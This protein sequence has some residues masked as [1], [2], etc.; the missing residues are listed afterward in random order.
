VREF[1]NRLV[2]WI[3]APVA[4]KIH[5]EIIC[6]TAV[7]QWF[8]VATQPPVHEGEYEVEIFFG[9]DSFGI[10]RNLYE[11]GRWHSSRGLFTP[12][13]GDKWRGIAKE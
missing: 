11:N 2:E 1:F 13:P 7:T 9:M 10:Q 6:V 4:Y 5:C 12:G 8:D 3:S